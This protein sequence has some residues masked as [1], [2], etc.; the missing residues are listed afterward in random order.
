M[1]WNKKLC[2]TLNVINGKSY[3]CGSKCVLRNYH[4][5]PDTKLG[6]GI[7]AIIRI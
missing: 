6:P 7:V 1:L 4:Y 5:R 3:P 2:P